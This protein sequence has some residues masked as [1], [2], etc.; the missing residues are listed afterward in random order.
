[1][2]ASDELFQLIRS[3]T[4]P[5][6]R[7]FKLFA[8]IYGGEKNYLR[9]F[10]AID[11]QECYDDEKLRATFAG[12]RFIRQL[13]VA[14]RYLYDQI[15]RS[16]RAY[17]EAA[18]V[19]ARIRELVRNIEILYEKGLLDQ[20]RK[21]FSTAL[22]LATSSE[23]FVM[24]VE[25]LGWR[26]A[27]EP[28]SATS[29]EGIDR[30]F[31]SIREA[32]E[33]YRNFIDHS[34]AS[35]KIALPVLGGDQPRTPGELKVLEDGLQLIPEGEGSILSVRAA[36]LY[37]WSYATYH[38][39]RR[40]YSQALRY[41]EH[42]VSLM[43]ENPSLIDTYPLLYL[44][45]IGNQLV[46]LKRTDNVVAFWTTID[47]M[48]ARAEELMAR[49]QLWSP[50]LGADIFCTL[51]LNQLTLFI[52]FGEKRAYKDL[53]EKIEQGLVTHGNYLTPT[54]SMK[55]HHNLAL[56]Y[57]DLGDYRTS[58]DYNLR[59]VQSE[60]PDRALGTYYHSRLMNLVIHYELGNLELLEYLIPSTYRYFRSRN[61]IN[62]FEE[63]VLDFF[64]QLMRVKEGR[65]CLL[66]LFQETRERF[67][68]LHEDPLEA[69]SFRSFQYLDWLDEKIAA[70]RDSMPARPLDPPVSRRKSRVA[71]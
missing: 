26:E 3:L 61:I 41:T 48:N 63:T 1:M 47:R 24:M 57:F 52:G 36:I 54:M 62:R 59:V 67:A 34:V 32:L 9:L 60:L 16:L 7:Y 20:A 43:E 39:A 38:F 29:A 37:D 46:L 58:L 28:D 27:M 50:R 6:K 22:E 64:K 53:V 23:D 31:G 4:K 14:K 33:K 25:V 55:F 40:E 19:R 71:A 13:N 70:L 15:L 68:V 30:V 42:R 45:A 10:D 8:S 35:R 51:Y 2:R 49:T 17:H 21:M 69:D 11:A 44:A 5:E 66:A 12:E 56:L 18:G 65:Q